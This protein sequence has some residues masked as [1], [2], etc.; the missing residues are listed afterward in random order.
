M[1]SI[2]CSLHLQART[3]IQLNR[4]IFSLEKSFEKS[5]EKLRSVTSVEVIRVE[6]L[7]GSAV[8]AWIR[9]LASDPGLDHPQLR[10]EF[11]LAIAGTGRTVEVAVLRHQEEIVGFFPFVRTT[12]SWAE[13]AAGPTSD[14]EAIILRPDV[15]CSVP[16]LLAQCGLKGWTFAHLSTQQTLFEPFHAYVDDAPYMDLSN[17][18][19]AYRK[20]I[21]DSSR[22]TFVNFERKT[23]KLEREVGPISFE[24][25][26]DDIAGTLKLL[27][28]WKQRQLLK[29]GFNDMFH[30]PWVGQLLTLCSQH[31]TRAF[32]GILSVLKAGGQP[33]AIHFGLLS[34]RV[35]LSWIP[36]FH[37]N[38]QI[39]SPG[40]QLLIRIAES[41]AGD[42]VSRID[43][44]RG[45]NQLKD[46]LKSAA[47]H[48]AIGT[49]CPSVST[50]F[51][52]NSVLN[53]KRQ[54][55]SNA[56]I[57]KIWRRAKAATQSPE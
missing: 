35:F 12:N 41:V 49:A 39:Y 20:A 24:F 34:E 3:D 47:Y 1:G 10:P 11:I 48:L 19:G 46:K 8:Q 38:Y 33:V 32:S 44:G 36:T 9:I 6:H 45:E 50:A 56:W 51:L 28:E 15:E 4:R 53:I 17:G 2:G 21:C 18:F 43:L 25:R 55:R 40:K 31:Q 7:T 30:L 23:R 42:G 57:Y 54:L 5:F 16:R 52:R 37:P 29:Q 22:S 26:A 27:K 13:P 14:F